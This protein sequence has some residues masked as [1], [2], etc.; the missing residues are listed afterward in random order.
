MVAVPFWPVSSE[1]DQGEVAEW[2]KANDSKSVEGKPSVGSNPTL[3]VAIAEPFLTALMAVGIQ[4]G[5][6]LQLTQLLQTMP[7]QLGDQLP[8]AAAI[9]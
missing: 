4:Y 3:S 8:G 2:S 9:H 5:G 7:G 6:N 1:G